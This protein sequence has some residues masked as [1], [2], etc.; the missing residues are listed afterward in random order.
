MSHTEK[1]MKLACC[2]YEVPVGDAG[3]VHTNT[4]N[5][6]VQCHNCGHTYIAAPV[7]AQEPRKLTMSMFATVADLEAAK[8]A[9]KAAQPAPAQGEPIMPP[10]LMARLAHHAADDR[11]TA[12]S[13][14]T[15]REL[16]QLLNLR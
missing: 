8:A 12:F 11:N 5:G 10:D 2:G 4:F 9:Q 3:P 1:S 14:S 16:L 13:R 6:V 15:M 7:A